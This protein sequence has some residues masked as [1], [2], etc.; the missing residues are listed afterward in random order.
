M[1][2][3]RWL[4][5]TTKR[6]VGGGTVTATQE[7]FQR[8]LQFREGG[9]GCNGMT[10]PYIENGVTRMKMINPK[11]LGTDWHDVPVVKVVIDE[12]A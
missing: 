5:K 2:E 8:T 10:G 6:K 1:I 9:Y 12:T 11:W 4:D 7:D 3:M